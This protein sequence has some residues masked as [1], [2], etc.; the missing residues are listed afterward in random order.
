LPPRFDHVGVVVDDLDAA[1]EF[2]LLIGFEH[3][4]RGMVDGEDVDKIN[5]LDGVRAEFLFVRTPDQTGSLELIK[6]HAPSGGEGPQALPANRP[7]YR[8]V[9]VEVEGLKAIVDELKARGFS[10]VGEVGELAEKLTG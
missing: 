6:Y 9:C 8:H 7:G 4:G 10:T 3:G 5:G 1:A 2:F